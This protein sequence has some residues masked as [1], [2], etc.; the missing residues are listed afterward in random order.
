MT[1]AAHPDERRRCGECGGEVAPDRYCLQ[2][3]VRAPDPRDHDR[4][5]PASWV[6]GVCDRGRHKPGN[7]DALALAASATPGE[8]AALVVLDGVSMADDSAAASL[9]G[10][11]AAC[12]VLRSAP[13]V[14]GTPDPLVSAT[15]AAADAVTAHAEPGSAN[16]ASATFLA[17][18]VTGDR[19]RHAGVGDSRAYWVPDAG[20][21]VQLTTDDSLARVQMDAGVARDVAEA[22][23]QAHA[24]TK[25]LGRDSED[26]SP[27]IGED[28]VVGPG[29]VVACTDGLWH[30]ASAASAL[31]ACVTRLGGGSA[32]ELAEGLWRF[33][34]EAGGHDNI[35]VAVARVG[36]V[37]DNGD[38]ERAGEATDG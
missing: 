29:W 21:A 12:E 38:S 35:T 8:Y 4:Q 3:G 20:V 11:R 37:R 34:L 31:Q 14:D 32:A 22:S 16:P 36:A 28:T 9:A 2:C 19:V 5:R 33:A 6:A 24:I 10:A 27:R 30:Y 13:V 15:E 18:T 17:V 26:P 23:P 25:W 7:E 1:S